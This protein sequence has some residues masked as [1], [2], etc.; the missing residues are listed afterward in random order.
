MT[1]YTRKQQRQILCESI[2]DGIWQLRKAGYHGV[3][4]VGFTDIDP[5][6]YSIHG[7]ELFKK[8]MAGRRPFGLEVLENEIETDEIPLS[9]YPMEQLRDIC[10]YIKLQLSKER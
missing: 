6:L 1:Q 7:G 8:Y 4:A 5:S 10:Q 9:R 3:V 2:T